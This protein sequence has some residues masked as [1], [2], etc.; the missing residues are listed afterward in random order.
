MRHGTF[1]RHCMEKASWRGQSRGSRKK[2]S[3]VQENHKFK[4]LWD[5]NIQCDHAITARQIFCKLIKEAN[6]TDI[7]M[8]GNLKWKKREP[9]IVKKVSFFERSDLQTLVFRDSARCVTVL[10]S[11]AETGY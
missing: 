2:P 3:G 1:T 8:P 9:E 6:S 4:I 10:K 5:I 7:V 11:V